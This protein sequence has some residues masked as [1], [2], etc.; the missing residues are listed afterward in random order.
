[1]KWSG[2][3]V[4]ISVYNNNPHFKIF[5][6]CTKINVLHKQIK[7]ENITD[8]LTTLSSEYSTRFSFDNLACYC[9][10]ILIC[11]IPRA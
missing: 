7:N 10:F 5:I 9:G 11:W 3:D 1:M 2:L 8:I 4:Q 6:E